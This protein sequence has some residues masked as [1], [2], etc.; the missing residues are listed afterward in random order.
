MVKMGLQPDRCHSMIT[1]N[2]RKKVGL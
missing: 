1:L 2:Q